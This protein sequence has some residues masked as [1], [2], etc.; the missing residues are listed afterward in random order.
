MNREQY[1][2][3]K[4]AEEATAVAKEA[5]K[6]MQFGVYERFKDYEENNATRMLTGVKKLN[7][8]VNFLQAELGNTQS[9]TY[10]TDEYSERLARTNQYARYSQHLGQ[11]AWDG[12]PYS[13]EEYEKLLNSSK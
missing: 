10:T 2:L 7:A 12:V 9:V 5:M 1:L 8:H 13:Q 4:V 3:L 6:C 11:V